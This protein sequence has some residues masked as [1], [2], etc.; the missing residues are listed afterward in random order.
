[1]KKLLPILLVAAGIAGGGAAGMILK[2]AHDPV[3]GAPASPAT[4]L[5]GAEPSSDS[6]AM[7]GHGND[8]GD[9]GDGHGAAAPG[10]H[11]YVEIGRQMIIPIVEGGETRALMMFELALDVPTEMR[12]T[13]F[14]HEPRIRDVFLREL[15]AMSHTGAFLG[16]FT[17]DLIVEE[18]RRNLLGAARRQLG[19][20]VSDVLIL[21]IMRQEM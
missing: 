12:E 6:G 20:E 15:F 7:D 3:D 4:D 13:V 19:P 8:H 5:H 1:M 21:D 10:G 18:L 14:L 17:D 16:T 11:D 2:P 9:A